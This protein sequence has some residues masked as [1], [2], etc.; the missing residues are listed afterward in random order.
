MATVPVKHGVN[1][2]DPRVH[3]RAIPAAISKTPATPFCLSARQCKKTSIVLIEAPSGDAKTPTVVSPPKRNSSG[4]QP[5]FGFRENYYFRPKELTRTPIALTNPYIR[6][7]FHDDVRIIGSVSLILFVSENGQ[8]D[9]I[10]ID[11]S[12]LPASYIEEII[13]GHRGMTFKP[14]DL[15]GRPVKSQT[16]IEINLSTDLDDLIFGASAE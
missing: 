13:V 5:L 14:G 8:V 11:Q 4:P 3:A 7:P 12:S 15:N 9:D 1:R 16:I 2:L 6:L 10:M